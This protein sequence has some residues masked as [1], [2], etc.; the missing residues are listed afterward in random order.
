[1][2]LPHAM[3]LATAAR[4][5]PLALLSAPDAD[6][7]L[8][9]RRIS[10]LKAVDPIQCLCLHEVLLPGQRMRL[11][12]MPEHFHEI[13]RGNLTVGV[14]GCEGGGDRLSVLSYGVEAIVTDLKREFCDTGYG[15]AC[16]YSATLIGGRIFALTHEQTGAAPGDVFLAPEARWID[17]GLADQLSAARSPSRSV[18]LCARE[19]GPLVETWLELARGGGST[20]WGRPRAQAK[21][22]SGGVDPADASRL[23][24]ATDRM[25]ADLGP[26]PGLDRPSERALWAAALINPCGADR[27]AWPVLDIRAAILTAR[28]PM[29]RLSAAKTGLIDSMYK[30]KGGNWPMNT[31]YW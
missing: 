2:R 12:L 17:L 22:M 19:L 27:Y 14:L 4:R 30:L 10:E 18:D 3:L 25:L 9:S 15:D 6:L 13:L 8:L 26:M 29:E 11:S 20:L 24:N 16:R 5:A 23:Q 21:L 31:Y 1:M 28:T 7:A